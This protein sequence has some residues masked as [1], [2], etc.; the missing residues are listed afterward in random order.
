MVLKAVF[1]EF[2]GVIARDI[3]LRRELIDEILIAENLRPNP[4]EYVEV[5]SGRSDRACLNDL[6]TRR[7]RVTTT[8]LLNKL[9]T[10]KSQNY[11]QRLTQNQ[12]RLLYPGIEDLLYK[13]KT[14]SLL[15]GIVTGTAKT[16]VEWVLQQMNLTDSFSV[17]VTA[18]D[19]A[20]EDEKPSAK[21]YQIAIARL[22]EQRPNLLLTADECVAV[23]AF[24][25]GIEA[26]QNASI[27]VI[28]VAHCY[29]YR[30]VQRRADW[31]VDYLVEIDF[32]WIRR[33]YDPNVPIVE[34]SL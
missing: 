12:K 14:D 23:E 7:G 16:E 2:N 10:Q 19:L 9:L 4:D 26:A 17:I 13:A 27:P 31:V 25:P 20:L 15:L 22:N 30:M 24:Y 5:C 33:R 29:P 34:E 32:A 18:E 1:L 3:T 11:I 8:E 6:L 21:G 28:G